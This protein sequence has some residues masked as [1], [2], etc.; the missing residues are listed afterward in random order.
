MNNKNFL[1]LYCSFHVRNSKLF[2]ELC[3]KDGRKSKY[4][5]ITNHSIRV[6][7]LLVSIEVRF[8]INLSL[9]T[10]FFLKTAPDILGPPLHFHM[11]FK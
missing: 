3:A 2:E 1:L 4:I 10:F 9:P 6:A 7:A 8:E 11:Q 5:F